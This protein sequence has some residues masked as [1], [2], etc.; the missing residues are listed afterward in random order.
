MPVGDEVTRVGE[1]SVAR[2]ID[3]MGIVL[4]V[5]AGDDIRL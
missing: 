2:V 4:D 3:T 5:W 1:N